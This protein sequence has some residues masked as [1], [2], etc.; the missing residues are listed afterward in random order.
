MKKIKILFV[1]GTRPEAI[2]LV[3]LVKL[4]KN[5]SNFICKVCITG[6]H[7]QMLDQVLKLY[8]IEPDF[9][10]EIM[11]PNQDL[12]DVT[13]KTLL[14][15]RNIFL[16]WSPNMVLVQGDTS[17]AFTT[18]LSAFYQKVEV[19][20]IEA[21][22]RTGNKYSPWPEEMNRVLISKIASLH[23]APTHLSKTNL[24]KE[25]IDKNNIHVTGN[26]V[27]DSLLEMHKKIQEPEIIKN[28]AKKF[29][30][31]DQSKKIILV[32]GHRRE[33]FGKGFENMCL[34]IKKISKISN[35]QIIYPVHLNPNVQEP[36]NRILGGSENINLIKPLDYLPF[37]YLMSK[38][39]II[40]TD[41]GGIQEEASAYNIPLLVMRDNTERSESMDTKTVQLVG[42][43][44]AM[45][46]KE[47]LKFLDLDFEPHFDLSNNPFGDG[48]SSEKIIEIILD[49]YRKN[50]KH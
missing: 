39:S 27:M 20:H 5:N 42:T 26:T 50:P 18:A 9:D 29:N 44:A 15:L 24:I 47:T 22:L 41:S 25:N 40:I 10:L 14:G 6:Q 11:E 21:G 31:L 28:M 19:G 43:D 34:G 1:F 38:S 3:K 49:F 23:F 17:T 35:V 48:K 32:T 4:V 37:I 36:V 7:K 33:N 2:K 13:K 8:N 12:T 30:F 45:I 46:Y 16:N